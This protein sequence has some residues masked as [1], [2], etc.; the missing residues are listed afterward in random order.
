MKVGMNMKL[1]LIL[2]LTLFLFPLL[3]QGQ[4]TGKTDVWDFGAEQLDTALYNNQLTETII[5]SWYDPGI[6]VGSSGNVL[7]N[8]FN[9]G[10]LSWIGG[11]NDRL[12]TTNTNLTRYDENISTA[13]GYT[14][15]VYV[16]SA[17]NVNRFMRLILGEDDEVTVIAK[18]DAGGILNFQYDDDPLAQT[19]VVPATSDL[20]ELHFV[21][22]EAGTY[23]LFDTQGKPSYYR[24]SRK[25]A[26][27]V[28]LT[29]GVDVSQAPGIPADYTI[30]F[31]NAAGKSWSSLVSNGSYNMEIPAGYT[32]E[33]S[34][35]GANGYIISNGTSLEVTET[36]T[37]HEITIVKVDLYTLSG[38][39]T[40][41]GA[42]IFD[43]SLTYTPDPLSGSIYE[44]ALV[45]DAGAATYSIL[46]EPDVLYSISAE[47]VNDFSIE[48][49]TIII[50]NANTNADII[51]N[52]KPVY[53]VA[54]EAPGLTSGQLDQLALTFSNLN[55]PGYEYAFSSATDV[56]LR[57]G[58]YTVAA[59]G[60]DEY[61]LALTLTSN[62]TVA[63]ADT[64]KT[65]SFVPVTVWSF[66]DRVISYGDPAYKGMLFT[67][68]IANEITKGHLTAKQGSTIQVPVNPGERV[69]ITYYYTADFSIE[70]GSAI[71][72]NTQSTNILEKVDYDYP[73]SAAGYVTIAVGS[74]VSTT[75]ITEI[76]VA[77][78]IPY[79][80]MIT[81]GVDKDYQTINEALDAVRHMDRDDEQRATILID[82]GNYE[83]MLFV[84]EPGI[85]LKNAAV[86][87]SIDLFNNGVDIDPNAVRITCYYGHGY[88]YYSMGSNQKWNA[89]VLAVNKENGYPSAV[90]T[91]YYWDAT[92]VVLADDF[93]AEDIIFENSFNQYISQK[94]TEDIVVE[95]DGSKGPRPA[96]YGNTEVQNKSFV[97]R[98]AAIAIPSGSDRAILNKC[99]V[100]GRQDSFF[101]GNGSRVV[102]YKGS[103]MGAVDYIFGDMTAVFYKTELAMNTS[104]GSSDQS[105]LTAAKQTGTRGFLMYECTVTSAKPGLENA[106]AYRSKPGY[107][108]RPWQANTSEVVFYNTTIETSDYPGSEGLSLIVPLGWQNS[109]G[110]ESSGMYE[111]GTIEES[112]VDNGPYR[113]TWATLLNQPVL[114]DGTEITPFNFTKGNDNW[115]PLPGLI[116]GDVTEVKNVLPLSAVQV[117]ASGNRVFISRVESTTTVNVFSLSGVLIQ[118]FE[119]NK[120]REFQLE[121]GFWIVEVIAAD[122]RKA[123]KVF[124]H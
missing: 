63:Q 88:D 52:P 77:T 111:Y 81:V 12:R 65:L 53:H 14:G 103:A 67:G 13:P 28:T 93:I 4:S 54:I 49:D 120:D 46:L 55:E 33:L 58:V 8:F 44:P 115:D 118:S 106:S 43:L 9:E 10:A 17:A 73:G 100:I 16:N 107:F 66:E 75:Y 84:D 24:I 25:D 59:G 5:N 101:G 74:S 42:A 37:T 109:L 69:T 90:N 51:F 45:I 98:A 47:G 41:L 116:N 20:V 79:D 89:E 31:T 91:H 80:S 50:G 113:A 30:V 48:T 108:G 15:R 105:Y 119:T 3:T 60:L 32:Y 123:V 7:P 124:T 76:S 72:T 26:T 22:K 38:A 104:D 102:V 87:P 92:V 86:E 56:Y 23:R 68:Q 19:D 82:P 95:A 71:T 70:G 18:T 2:Y 78:P 40:G 112:G 21:A 57:D 11:G 61:P 64:S 62:L 35:S 110:G 1:K 83:E 6:P 121:S 114:L 97:E 85:T 117:H 29:G 122:G 39:I 99:R 34:L 94:E 27:Y 36:T 96:E